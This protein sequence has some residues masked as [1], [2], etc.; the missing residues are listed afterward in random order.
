MI[1]V[2]LVSHKTFYSFTMSHAAFSFGFSMS[3][4]TQNFSGV[5]DLVIASD[6]LRNNGCRLAVAAKKMFI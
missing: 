3:C 5:D 4:Y 1:F 2:E 6:A